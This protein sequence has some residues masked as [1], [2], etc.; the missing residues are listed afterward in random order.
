MFSAFALYSALNT[1]VCASVYDV[2]FL[3]LQLQPMEAK[4]AE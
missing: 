1:C 2:L 4:E 3:N